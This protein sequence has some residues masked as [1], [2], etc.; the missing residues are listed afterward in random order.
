M[1]CKFETITDCLVHGQR[2]IAMQINIIVLFNTLAV[3]KVNVKMTSKHVSTLEM[4][5]I[6]ELYLYPN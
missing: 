3:S 5:E 1:P 6:P 4:A 2:Q